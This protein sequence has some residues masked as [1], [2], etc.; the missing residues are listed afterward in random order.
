MSL[1]RSLALLA[2]LFAAAP[3]GALAQSASAA[4]KGARTGEQVYT[5]VCAACHASGVAGSPKFGDA[6]TWKPLIEEGQAVLTAHA[7]V[8]VR[9]MPARGGAPDLTLAEF[10][11]GAA[12]MARGAGGTWSDPDA[13]M[14]RKIAAEASK[15]LDRNIREA[16]ELKAHLKAAAR[17]IR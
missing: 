14:L 12:H 1:A 2:A 9:G 4:P 6:A 5:Q 7:F 11:R 15:R 3:L 13:A 17:D 16:Q 8:G 10:A